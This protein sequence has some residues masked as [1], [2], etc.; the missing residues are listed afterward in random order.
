MTREKK[1]ERREFIRL[2]Y[3]RPLMYKVCK[4]A[5]I[6]K[7]LKGYTH[8]ISSAGLMCNLQEK[9][10]KDCILWLQLDPGAL[11]LCEEIERR[12]VIIQHGVLAKVV[13]EKKKGENDSYDI[14]VCFIT[15]EEK[16]Y[17]DVFE[18]FST[19]L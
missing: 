9:V 18:K 11:S 1:D 5:T 14:G 13:W 17:S 10:P 12:S 4:K 15:R 2:S 6:S 7:I 8:N 3:N 16:K 19:S